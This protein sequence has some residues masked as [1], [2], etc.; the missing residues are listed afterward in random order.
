[1]HYA[2]AFN[3]FYAIQALRM[4]RLY[5]SEVSHNTWRHNYEIFTLKNN[6]ICQTL[7][8]KVFMINIVELNA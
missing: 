4:P 7:K 2:L 5:E 3:C 6:G 1:M 8:Q